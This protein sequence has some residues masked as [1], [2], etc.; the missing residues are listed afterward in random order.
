MARPGWVKLLV[1]LLALSTGVSAALRLPHE[2]AAT[3]PGPLAT[4]SP[5]PELITVIAELKRFV[6]GTRGL[7]FKQDV[8]VTI[9]A[10][11]PFRE[12][13]LEQSEDEAERQEME[14]FELAMKALG[15]IEPDLDLQTAID[16]ALGAGV[17]GYYD[18]ETKELVVRA[19]ALGPSTRRTLVHELTHALQDQH[20]GL[21]RPEYLDRV[22]EV[23][24]GFQSIVE[25]DASRIDELYLK[26][27]SARDRAQV[28]TE[29]QEFGA[30]FPDDVPEALLHMIAF[31]YQY[32]PGVVEELLESGGQARLDAAF[33][34]PP[35]TS[36]QVLHPGRLLTGERPIQV[37]K[38]PAAGEVFDEGIF[39]EFALLVLFAQE[40][41]GPS[42]LDAAQGWGGDYY[43][44]WRTSE[45][46][47]IR[48]DLRMD[49]PGDQTEL[50]SALRKWAQ[51][52]DSVKVVPGPETSRFTSCASIG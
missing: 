4:Q 43:V 33:S 31:P 1:G 6:E 22:D 7:P 25:G 41:S 46:A 38:P 27:L 14:D 45:G 11:R 12:R 20:F 8:K 2:P 48:V 32:G 28:R 51:S 23:P 40:L 29:D 3:S 39:G 15:L 37:N 52:N 47:C 50:N 10:D 26:N 36:E 44:A 30:S 24:L 21:H 5:S 18:A 16:E 34:S 35:E 17:L 9:L 19:E 49:T 42:A 13:L